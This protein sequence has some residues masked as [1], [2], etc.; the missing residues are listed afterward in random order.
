LISSAQ[1]YDSAVLPNR[2]ENKERTKEM[3]RKLN[4]LLVLVMLSTLV[5]ISIIPASANTK[6]TFSD[7][8]YFFNPNAGFCA[9]GQSI[10]EDSY[11]IVDTT[12]HRNS[13]GELFIQEED[14]TMIGGFYLAD[15]PWKRL[16]YENAH[17]KNFIKPDG[18]S[19]SSGLVAKVTVPGYGILVKDIGHIV[20]ERDSAGN[21]VPVRF[22][23]QHDLVPNWNFSFMCDYLTALP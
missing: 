12:I 3:N 23:G 4:F 19:P 2:K 11:A 14:V 1:L 8:F 21:W 7:V 16:D 18:S 22:A 15:M 5:G 10:V 9:N 20:F 6:E 17:W 13:K